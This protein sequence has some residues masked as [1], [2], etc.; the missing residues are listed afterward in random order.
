[1]QK[2]IKRKKRTRGNRYLPLKG[3]AA[4]VE[5][6]E[7]SV[8]SVELPEFKPGDQV[9]VHVRIR[10]GEKERIQV[11]EGVVIGRSNRGGGR[12]FMVRKMSH[13][14]GVERIFLENSP[15]LA[16]VEVAQFGRV[17]RAKLYY[18]RGLVGR[19]AKIEQDLGASSANGPAVGS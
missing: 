5:G 1:M 18:L 4:L 2:Y 9:K 15:K 6:I 13:G 19:K 12:S 17:R 7:K 14:V 16:K 3:L 10:E 8:P 11:F